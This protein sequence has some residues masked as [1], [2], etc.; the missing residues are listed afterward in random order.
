MVI[1]FLL[2]GA[3]ATAQ[4]SAE[5][6]RLG[7]E[8]ANHG[9]LAALL[10]MMKGKEVDELVAAHRELSPAE[11]AKLR[12]MADRTFEQGRDR[13]LSATGR[14]YAQRLSVTDLRRLVAFYRTATA[15]RFQA[16]LP[17]VIGDTVAGLGKMDFKGDVL[18]AYCKETG[19]L[20]AAK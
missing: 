17:S 16:V 2:A 11:K 7:R 6:R 18:A 9:T 5:A 19:K 8:L 3:A 20:C 14:A 4:P 15:A 12:N 13:I 1:A 10:P